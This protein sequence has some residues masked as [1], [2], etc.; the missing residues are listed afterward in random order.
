MT[1]ALKMFTVSDSFFGRYEKLVVDTVIPYQE[2][3]LNDA[4]PGIEKSHAVENF[5]QAAEMNESGKCSS[6]F[7]GMVFQDSDVAKWLEAAAYS[8]AQKADPALEKRCDAM[9]ALIGR[10]QKSD[11]YLDTYFTV[12]EPGRQWTDL[13][14]A[15]ELY[16]A[17]HMMEAAVAYYECTGKKTLLD[18][19]SRMA[20]HIYNHFITHT[21]PGYPGH[22]EVELALMR[23]YHATGNGK[24]KELAEHFIN[25]RGVD[26]DYFK[27]ESATR[28][29]QVWGKWNGDKEYTLSH[30]PVRE[31]EDAVG[32][33]VRAVYLYSGMASVAAE[34]NDESLKKACV[35]LWNSITQKRMYVT[36]AIG[37]AY[38]GESFTKDYHLPNDTAYGETCASVGLIF[39]AR[40]MLDL[41]K[42]GEY[43][44]VME[45]ALYNCVLAGMQLDGKRFFYVN[46]LESLP[47]IS[48]KAVT[49]RHALPQRPQWFACACCPPN[50]ARLITS[51]G[52]YAWCVQNRT[53]YAVLYI[54]GTLDGTEQLGGKVHV[55]TAY[56]YEGTVTYSFE[57][58]NESMDMTLALRI[59]S[60]NRSTK[61]SMNG[62]EI[63][64]RRSNGYAFIQG[65][66]TVSDTVTI[67]FDMSVRRLY[68]SPK[69]SADS[70]KAAF[71]RGPLVYCAEGKDNNGSVLSLS[72]D[73]TDVPSVAAYEPD[74]LSGV[75]K[76]TVKGMRTEDNGQ[77]YS[78][79]PQVVTPCTITLIPYYAWANRGENEMRVWLPER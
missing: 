60:W 68:A 66:F 32:H 19:M 55:D 64:C 65:P 25:V 41:F 21:I 53:A 62:K 15:H 44:D 72:T 29:W 49:H 22:P 18:I 11:G 20:D 78:D 8:L 57:P 9:I 45:R 5:I 17:G 27:H 16:C 58:V 40:R 14:E 34:T 63:N 46:A 12:K 26:S 24:Y 67:E 50:V 54:G 71:M 37:S 23:M 70:G 1:D 7:Y 43:G 38:E 31:Q 56:P 30:K 36:G 28:G 59:P 33:A 69:V 61:I 73:R 6:E 39:F 48:G 79:V 35:T 76:I 51:I 47:G 77:L 74:L 2:K 10:A 13:Q 52:R 3:I 75:R 4:I 42:D